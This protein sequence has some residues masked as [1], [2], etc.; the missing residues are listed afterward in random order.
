[1]ESDINL[2]KIIKHIDGA[3][4]VK[5]ISIDS[6]VEM[7]KVLKYLQN[8]MFHGFIQMVDLFCFSNRYCLTDEIHRLEIKI[9]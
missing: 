8:L 7:E 5:R 1:M 2:Y 4:C 6:E 3:K 9:K